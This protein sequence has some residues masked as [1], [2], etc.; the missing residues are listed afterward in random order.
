MLNLLRSNSVKSAITSIKSACAF[1]RSDIQLPRLKQSKRSRQ[2]RWMN[3]SETLETRT[4]LAATPAVAINAPSDAFIGSNV[5]LTV[6]FD[7]TGS[8]SETGYGPII[9]VVLPVNGIDG[10][11]SPDGLNTTGPATYLGTPITTIEL[12][13]P[14]GG[15]GTGT[16]NHPFFK[17]SAGNPLTVTGNT[18]D[19][20]IVMQLPFG[21]FTPAQP[22]AAV[23]LPLTMSNLADLN[24]PLA[25]RTRSG[26]QYGVDP[27]DNPASDPSLVSD[28]PSNSST[29]GVSAGVTP[30]LTRLRKQNLAPESE[31]ATGPN[32]PRQY[33]IV[34]E[35]AQGQTITN[36]DVTDLL[37]P[38]IVY[39]GNGTVNVSPSLSP[40]IISSPLTTGPQNSPDNNLTVRIPTVTGGV[41]NSGFTMTYGFYVNQ[42]NAS[43]T[44]VINATTADDTNTLNTA[45]A[46]GDWNPIDVR[47][48][49]GVNNAVGLETVA[50][51]DDTLEN[52]SIAVQKSVMII[53][54]NGG[55]GATPGDVLEYTLEFQVS[56][57][58]AFRD[59]FLNDLLSDGQRI[60]DTFT[61]RMFV[62]EHG[63]TS[64]LAA[65]AGAN[66]T[67]ADNFTGL[68]DAGAAAGS[69][70]SHVV[71]V[72]VAAGSQ[73]V[74]F[75]ISN[76]LVSRGGGF[77]D[78][79]LVGGAIPNG[80]TGGPAPASAA[81]LPFGGTLGRIVYRSVIQDDFSDNFPS[82]D[83]SVDIGDV[84][85]N[86]AVI[87]GAV[88]SVANL[89]PNGNRE[90]DDTAAQIAIT[91]GTL[92]K[93]IYAINGSTSFATPI[94]VAPGDTVTYRL[95]FDLPTSDI[96]GLGFIDYLPLPVFAS[97]EVDGPF[98]T[99]IS[100]AAPAAGQAKFGPTDTFYA[101]S[102]SVLGGTGLTP[103]I[104]SDN[105][106]NS[107]QFMYG[108]FD[109][110][111]NSPSQI[112]ILFTVTVSDDP[113]ADGLFLT[114]QV[115]QVET[116]TNA[117]DAFNDA[118]VQ[119]SLGEPDLNIRK[120]VVGSNSGGT[121][122]PATVGPVGFGTPGTGDNNAATPEFVGTITST[123]LAAT[124]INSNL[125]GIDAGDIVRFAV[126]VENTGSSRLGAF[127]V[128]LRDTIPA[129]FAVPGSGLKMS[130]TDGTGAALTFTD[131]GGG[132][133]GS[134]LMLNDPGA[135]TATGDGSNGGA[136]DAFNP[137][138]GR[139]I[140]IVTYDLVL[141]STVSPSSNLTNTATLISYAGAEGSPNH[142]PAGLTET[143]VVTV[144]QPIVDKVITT[145]NQGHTS[146]TNVAIG[147]IV[148]Y[149]VTVTV[150]EGQSAATQL[151]DTLDAGL[152][153]VDIV[154]IT[155]SSGAL[156]ASA[157]TFAAI[158][159]ATTFGAVGSGAVNAGRLMTI[160]F[161]TLVNSDTNN[162]TAETLTIVY[163]AAVLNTTAN[164]RG[165]GR[166]N[167]AA[168]NWT[169]GSVVDG[170]PNVIIVE[171]TLDIVK[172]MSP[173]TADA[174]DTVTITLLLQ[175]AASSNANA[176]EVNLQDILP[177]GLTYVGGSLT[178]T[179]GA[180][181]TTGPTESSGTI[182]AGWTSFPLGTTSTLT[183]Q[184]TLT[185]AVIPGS[186]ITNTATSNWTGL[187]TDVTATQSTLNTLA[188]ERTGNPANPGGTA[189]NYTDPGIASINVTSPAPV[190][191]IVST[192]ETH[193]AIG[194]GTVIDPSRVAV[195]E[196]IRYRLRTTLPEGTSPN[197]RLVDILP[198][199]LSLLDLSQ[200]MVSFSADSDITEAVDLAGADNDA[201][202]PTFVLPAGR[203]SQSGQTITFDLGT[204]VNNDRDAGAELI[205][206]EFNVLV[207][208]ALVNQNV[209]QHSNN[210]TVQVNGSNIA[211]SNSVVS[212]VVEPAITNVTK[213]VTTFSTGS[214]TYQVTYS[215]TGTTT[216]FDVQ[217]HDVLPS[218][219]LTLNVASVNVVTAGGAA[220][221]TD[222]SAG[223]TVG[224]LL[225][226]IPVGGSVTITY[227]ASVNS[228][229]QS[230]AIPNT[231]AVTY[232]S[233]PGGGTAVNA[234][235]STTPVNGERTGADGPGGALNDYAN[236][237]SA[238]LGALGDRVWYDVDADATQDAG[239]PGIAGVTMALT[240][241]GP[242]G[243]LGGG[244]DVTATQVTGANGGYQ[245]VGLPA[246][247]YR[248][249]ADT[250]DLPAGMAQTFDFSG[251]QSDSTSNRTLSGGQIAIDQDF[252]YRGTGSLGDTVWY[253]INSSGTQ[254]GTEPGISG[255][256]VTLNI[257]FDRDGTTDVVLNRVTNQ[258]GQYLF[259]NLPFA[260]YTVVAT[261]P[262]GANQTFDASGSQTDHTSTLTLPGGANN[263]LQDF[264]YVGTGSV[265]DRVWYDQ[266]NNGV[267]DA[268]E[269]G[270]SGVTVLLDIDFN[271]DGTVDHT[272]TTTTNPT[273]NYLFP[274]LPVGSYTVR[275][276][277]VPAGT[278][279]TFDA[280]GTG[281]A[282]RSSLVL[283]SGQNNL[284]QDFGYRGTG[285]IGDRV[286]FDQDQDASQ[287]VGEP[288][289]VGVP[290]ALDIDLNGDAVIDMTL[291]TVT[292]ANGAYLFNNLPAGNY[293]V[294]VT[295]PVGTNQSYD[296]SGSQ[297]DD[298]S[299]LTLAAGANNLL[300]DFGYF[301]R[302]TIGDTVFFD[303]NGDGI[304]N[305]QD[306]GIPGATVLLSA[307]L[308]G[309]GTA[310]YTSTMVTDGLGRYLFPALAPGN[311]TITA[312]QPAGTTQ[313]FD[314]NGPLNNQSAHI[315]GVDE[316]NVLQDFGY[317]GTGSI[318]DRVWFDADAD[319]VQDVGEPGFVGVPVGL[320]VDLN[321]DG[322]FEVTL[323]TT[324]AANG[325][326]SF[327]N[328]PA[329]SYRV[330]VT[331][332][333]TGT[334]QTF[335]A[336][337]SQSDSTSN[338]VLAAGA[339]NVL[340]D[341][342]YRGT[343]S[344]GDRVWFDADSDGVQ[345]AG[346]SGIP[347][348]P[349]TLA[350]DL[351]GDGLTDYTTVQ[352]TVGATG[353]YL[354]TNLPPG[355]YTITATQPPGTVQTFDASGSQT[356]NRSNLTLTAGQ[357]NL[358]QD[359]GYKGV[360]TGT[361]GD[362]VW[363]DR[364]GNG[365]QDAGEP[366]LA[367]VTV[368]L[369]LD[370]NGDGTPDYTE[371]QT[372]NGSGN[373]LFVDLIPG[374]YTVIVTPPLNMTQTADPDATL[375]NRSQV[376]LAAG[377]NNLTQ[378]FGYQGTGTIGDLI[379]RDQNGSGTLDAGDTGISNVT[380]NLS[381]DIDGDGIAETF[382]NQ[383]NATGVYSFTNL[384]VTTPTGAAILYTVSVVS[385]SLPITVT[386][387][388]D[389]DGTADNQSTV[390]L[391]VASLINN[392]IDFGY[393][394]LV[395]LA[396]TKTNTDPSNN[397]LPTEAVTYSIVVTNAGPGPAVNAHVIDNFP[398]QIVSSS[399][400][401]TGS[402]GTV[403]SPAGSG[404]MNDTVFIP[405]N[406]TITYT[407]TTT[408]NGTFLGDLT[409]T[410][411]VSTVQIDTNPLNNSS[412][413]VTRISPIVV[414]A[415]TPPIAGQ[416]VTFRARGQALHTALIP[417]AIGTS[418][419]ASVVNGV[420]LGIANATVFGIG[421]QCGGGE[422]EAFFTLP[423]SYA[424]QTVYVQAFET[425]PDRL[426]SNVLPVTVAAGAP[427]VTGPVGNTSLPRPTFMWT[428]TAGVTS[429][430][431][432][433]N[434]LT[435]GTSQYIRQTVSGTSFTPTSDM[436][437][438][439]YSV[440]V[441]GIR[442]DG[443][444][445]AWS[446]PIVTE[447]NAPAQFITTNISTPSQQPTIS[448]SPLAGA[449]R[450]DLWIDNI[451]TGAS[452]VIR[453][454]NVLTTSY[455]P[456]T[457]LNFGA[458]RV[459]VRGLDVTG[460]PGDWSSAV[461][462]NVT[463][464]P[465]LTGPATVTVDSTPTFAWNA[466]TGANRYDLWVN[467]LTTGTNQ[468]IR[469]TALPTTTFTPGANLQ[470]GQYQWWVR[471][472][473]TSTTG[474]VT[475]TWSVGRVVTIGGAPT[476]LTPGASTS[477][478]TPTFTWNAIQGAANYQI[479]V[480]RIG[481]PAA[482]INQSGVVGT[483]FTSATP[484]A[485]GGYRVWLRAVGT[486]GTIGNWSS[487]VDFSV[488]SN[489]ISDDG[490][491]LPETELLKHLTALDDEVLV[492][493]D[494]HP[495][496]TDAQKSP[497]QA[498]E[499]DQL[500]AT[501]RSLV[502]AAG[503]V[504]ARSANRDVLIPHQASGVELID[505]LDS[506]DYILAQV[507]FQAWDV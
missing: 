235:G 205:T 105:A 62:Q 94:H 310:D 441:Q 51:P 122:S 372:T 34:V 118:I 422:V 385:S 61:P 38:E 36:F 410:A 159:T 40:N 488:V 436:A 415:F 217:M 476:L 502:S 500:V 323:T 147:E 391:T 110:P 321:G 432:W 384:P 241:F 499:G 270:F 240:W 83:R 327:N 208:N 47:D 483:S 358:T 151:V 192:S 239:E 496:E 505:D 373:Y 165:A 388:V 175:H 207:T 267:Q 115:R 197:E 144:A 380:V 136:V 311:Y 223:N 260:D 140:V 307:D 258:T 273:G 37:P 341:F 442:G 190:K 455:T 23:N 453:N 49:G 467:N 494:Q 490:S 5:N 27:L 179:A 252:G 329:G 462:I 445:T 266:N 32:F 451:T 72:G 188:V 15:G 280:D 378:D 211:T 186:I 232:T 394:E 153:F 177:A 367:N 423:A 268:A 407:V 300:Q 470:K 178:H 119:I 237:G 351:N 60:D 461:Q 429:Y 114:N 371:S 370:V 79:Q 64:T 349:V 288:G 12:T 214:V 342:G 392:T 339:N 143:A 309:D 279:P 416:P 348:V 123:N 21:S 383:T 99:T 35:V 486:D 438:G 108:D 228:A 475:G 305:G 201:V 419:G 395:D 26:F 485:P 482:I 424:G 293:I 50:G 491:I 271:Q 129:G 481:G 289:F 87:D 377:V 413:N 209:V 430:D 222:S 362:F 145:T 477:D 70:P 325:A 374:A 330:R 198:N 382:T 459:W 344:I 278:A 20:L 85:T 82:G 421:V 484:L 206:L 357:N 444:R 501:D 111:A 297:V 133:F 168:F 361:I 84:L 259:P 77:A 204:L 347:N 29:W 90:A 504:S 170:A 44:P 326:Y 89:T 169:G 306:V 225:S 156:T 128:A 503:S 498:P 389:P 135:T 433:I 396:I 506:L 426:A 286:W 100:A 10:G 247:N 434:S 291:N 431:L 39:L 249:V 187:P 439:R 149:T 406:G 409:N 246:G 316:N 386:P 397:R 296:A 17:N 131:L 354:F 226:T 75:R 236:N 287:T 43:A 480:D 428:G 251:S 265:G 363:L 319:D 154:S 174:G 173:A 437:I 356:D 233:L 495:E 141:A 212:Q 86:T 350:L 320:D 333:P 402:T 304:M 171:P 202:A 127:D 210:F 69:G 298:R 8:G 162:A 160:N 460:N 109:D 112:D 120:G 231:A 381:G 290:V 203:I 464:A 182:T 261:P 446:S 285:S 16:V 101:N 414:S 191:F 80:G 121:F 353:S 324:T 253:D 454:A 229:T 68:T 469:Q 474:P 234:T 220:G 425:Q 13:F 25:I 104:S 96:E 93:Q 116:S 337:G 493:V 126:V 465:V 248:V 473:S 1:D 375:N 7:N 299:G 172:T 92:L 9:D 199:G 193:T 146:G 283:G 59:V 312:V 45:V 263:L 33:E 28:S 195:G 366:G 328:L 155:P 457:S 405:V 142:I 6:S 243:A 218:P 213:S 345:D 14:N 189:N 256:T 216:A 360:G 53:T 158:T 458:Y 313:T 314:A 137:T 369:Q 167:S 262:G 332:S 343:G 152:G 139:N 359:F 449:T 150:P 74:R 52:Q 113:F 238:S 281:T 41:G 185:G 18:G 102:V 250:A 134:G 404:N 230:A 276:P 245:F 219:A 215:N 95:L 387:F 468:V 401:A 56:D 443:T 463:P 200:V 294:R 492:L 472:I 411:S 308:D 73:Q 269:P 242:N 420:T 284:L 78:G 183:L 450:Y 335:D 447:V 456:P 24:A 257:D 398:A 336:S 277:T 71:D 221:V 418:L 103:V 42:F 57:Y 255:V 4:L 368:T 352:N 334:V 67:I 88:L 22:A 318:G 295:R 106:A 54:D 303:I 3:T 322:T 417:F 163:R 244:D 58:F 403:F 65:F 66:F 282:N 292:G 390:T 2:S 317:R 97:P 46:I 194:S 124:P 355:A 148:T 138:S 408:L 274:N 30:I 130:V 125:S 507:D 346:E 91:R 19:K 478:T 487:A 331:A 440:F 272:L 497:A 448:W 76:E 479:W 132:L 176:F 302:G 196:I 340:Q 338:V 107:L 379:Y 399:W 224:V 275:I 161:G 48:A 184:A 166:N 376:A 364:N 489:D 157:G 81:P 471:A 254:N 412:T 365:T 98:I 31:T 393:V 11:A 63:D 227:T 435:T 180:A 427:A 164:V 264:G 466:V 117:G 55:A 452:Q 301:G 315:L 181:P 400:V